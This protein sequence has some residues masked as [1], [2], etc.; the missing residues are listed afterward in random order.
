MHQ[1]RRHLRSGDFKNAGVL[2]LPTSKPSV[3]QSSQSVSKSEDRLGR[4]DLTW[5]WNRLEL[6]IKSRPALFVKST[7]WSDCPTTREPNV[8]H[9]LLMCV[10]V[11]VC[12]GVHVHVCPISRA[13]PREDHTHPR[14]LWLG[15]L[16]AIWVGIKVLLALPRRGGPAPTQVLGRGRHM[17][18]TSDRA[19]P[20]KAALGCGSLRGP[21]RH[22]PSD[23]WVGRPWPRPKTQVAVTKMRRLRPMGSRRPAPGCGCPTPAAWGDRL[24][25]CPSPVDRPHAAEGP[26]RGTR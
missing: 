10:H 25:A 2:H 26:L 23:Q 22:S 24:P 9:N 13:A 17:G 7:H 12:V 8:H 11:H 6:K 19:W 18:A 20:P 5:I 1:L 14:E 4:A 15:T 21:G 3:P 16:L